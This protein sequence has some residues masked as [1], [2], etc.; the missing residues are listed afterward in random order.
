MRR[1]KNTLKKLR[2]YEKNLKYMIE[3]LPRIK[4]RIEWR[5][6]LLKDCLTRIEFG[7]VRRI[8]MVHDKL[9]FSKNTSGVIIHILKRIKAKIRYIRKLESRKSAPLT[10]NELSI[11]ETRR[12]KYLTKNLNKTR[13]IEIVG[14]RGYKYIKSL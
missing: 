8:E 3:R 9:W 1:S 2:S 14:K 4:K 7:R 11:R 13:L 12:L 10:V 5:L 6:K